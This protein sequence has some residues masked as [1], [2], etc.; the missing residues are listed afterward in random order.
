M[1]RKVKG[2][3]FII[4][5]LFLICATIYGS[6]TEELSP[7][8]E[9]KLY[10]IEIHQKT[11]AEGIETGHV[12]AYGHYVKPPYKI[13]VKD[14]IVYVNGVQIF[15]PLVTEGE[16]ER[17]V[18]EEIATKEYK[19][20]EAEVRRKVESDSE[21]IQLK[22]KAMEAYRKAA[23]EGKRG[24]DPLRAAA[25]IFKASPRVDD[26]YV[27]GNAIAVYFKGM[28]PSYLITQEDF[29]PS[30][31]KTPEEIEKIVKQEEK[32]RKKTWEDLYSMAEKEG[33]PPNRYGWK[34]KEA[35]DE[36]KFLRGLLK[37]GGAV[38][39]ETHCSES[40]GEDDVVFIV[41]VLRDVSLSP[42]E[43]SI[44]L[45]SEWYICNFN[46]SEWPTLKEI[47][48][49]WKHGREYLKKA[50]ETLKVRRKEAREYIE[51]LE[52]AKKGGKK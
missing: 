28:R 43:K 20:K 21:L 37:G 49:S 40:M 2:L 46:P 31:R 5:G 4:G 45:R 30:L 15:P 13:E 3:R 32:M 51:R 36:A 12:I 35:N 8:E 9:V 16:K 42:L 1:Y 33:Y 11:P 14:T 34:L 50:E 29:D 41:R 23:K 18:K 44:I 17:R 22:Q 39:Y 6:N 27:G 7:K 10:R 47:E 25:E 24:R 48:N 19:K 52:R 26:V 38:R